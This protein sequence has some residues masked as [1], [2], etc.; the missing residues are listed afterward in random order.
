MDINMEITIYELLFLI[1]TSLGGFFALFQW[2]QSYKLKRAEH[3]KEAVTKIREDK[4]FAS[5]LYDIDYGVIWYTHD[6]VGTHSEEQ[7]FDMVFAY[8]DYLCYLKNKH[9]LSKSEFR[10]FDY[11]I[12]RMTKNKCFLNYMFNLYHFSKKNMADFSFYHLLA[13]LRKNKLLNES[14]WDVNSK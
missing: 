6:F 10:V 12:K 5:V 11:R 1:L 7:K 8:F 4:V 3:L 13:Y 14:F 2:R 9:I